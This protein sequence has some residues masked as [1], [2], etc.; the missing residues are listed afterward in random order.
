MGT[1]EDGYRNDGCHN[2]MTMWKIVRGFVETHPVVFAL[3]LL[4]IVAVPLHDVLIPHLA[5]KL[6]QSVREKKMRSAVWPILL[7]IFGVIVFIQV[8]DTIDN[9]IMELDEAAF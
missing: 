9:E 5:G 8:I 1:H 2:D 6:Y 7:I 4:C 3:Y